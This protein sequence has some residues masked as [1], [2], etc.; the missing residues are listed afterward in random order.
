MLWVV[1]HLTTDWVNARSTS[2]RQ[3][4]RKRPIPVRSTMHFYERPRDHARVLASTFN[5]KVAGS[6][7]ARPITSERNRDSER[8]AT[9]TV[10]K[11]TKAGITR[12]IPRSPRYRGRRKRGW[13]RATPNSTSPAPVWVN[14][15]STASTTDAARPARTQS[16]TSGGAGG[17]PPP[18]GSTVRVRQGLLR[19]PCK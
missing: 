8:Q 4:A 15:R 3:A 19:N 13:M 1:S 14:R 5:P 17:R 2:F 9:Q 18:W 12:R 16:E 10:L 11:I 7:P 6:I